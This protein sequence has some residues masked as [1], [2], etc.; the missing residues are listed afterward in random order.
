M[1]KITQVQK[2][3]QDWT[4]Q[5]RSSV[6]FSALLDERPSLLNSR[7]YTGQMALQHILAG[8]VH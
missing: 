6:L 5:P 8:H 1:P 4:G 3:S 7:V 2:L